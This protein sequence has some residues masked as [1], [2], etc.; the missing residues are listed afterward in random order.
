[1]A[2]GG[3]GNTRWMSRS[4]S[5]G[6]F[7]GREKLVMLAV[8]GRLL[9]VLLLLLLEGTR[10]AAEPSSAADDAR[11]RL[12]VTAPTSAPLP[13]SIPV[14]ADK[15][16][17]I[18]GM[19]GGGKVRAVIAAVPCLARCDGAGIIVAPMWLS[20]VDAALLSVSVDVA[21][22]AGFSGCCCS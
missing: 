12:R 1:V 9:L 21:D 4:G 10:E 14:R 22:A 18:E 11:R 6:T 19:V 2:G 15:V 8:V 5:A 3:L 7:G 13:A 20:E 16:A 17:R